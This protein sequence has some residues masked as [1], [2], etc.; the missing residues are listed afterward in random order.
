MNGEHLNSLAW[1]EWL[2][3]Q[4]PLN[5]SD[6]DMEKA[7][8]LKRKIYYKLPKG[9]G[10]SIDKAIEDLHL[11]GFWRGYNIVWLK[12][13]VFACEVMAKPIPEV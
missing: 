8:E 3:K 9:L 5:V 6:E 1:V 11:G 4:D 2:K 13:L 7:M 12:L 10:D